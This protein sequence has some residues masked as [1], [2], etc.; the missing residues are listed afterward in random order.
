MDPKLG[1]IAWSLEEGGW[2]G[3]KDGLRFSLGD[4]D[5]SPPSPGLKS[6]ANRMLSD[7]GFLVE[8]L[9]AA[10]ASAPDH[11]RRFEDEMKGL[12]FSHLYFSESPKGRYLFAALEPGPD[13]LC[14]RLEFLEDECVGI[15]FDT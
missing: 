2:T 5:D 8:S 10:I 7:S 11:L 3:V 13:N 6:W 4:E 14:W 12:R 1:W 15:G 9:E